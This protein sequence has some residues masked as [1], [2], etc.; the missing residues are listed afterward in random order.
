MNIVTNRFGQ[1]DLQTNFEY[2][3]PRTTPQAGTIQESFSYRKR[4]ITWDD[5]GHNSSFSHWFL[6]STN[7]IEYPS[8]IKSQTTSH[9]RSNSQIKYLERDLYTGNP[10][11]TLEI[12]ANENTKLNEIIPAYCVYPE[13][14]LKAI[15]VNNHNMLTQDAAMYTWLSDIGGAKKG[16][17]AGN[18]QT[19]KKDWSYRSWDLSNSRFTDVYYSGKDVYRKES[20]YVW[21]GELEDNSGSKGV[22][23]IKPEYPSYVVIDESNEYPYWNNL[24]S[25]EGGTSSNPWMRVAKVT[26]YT[27]R[28]EPLESVA[29][30]GIYSASKMSADGTKIIGTISNSNYTS[31]ACTGFEDEY[32]LDGWYSSYGSEIISSNPYGNVRVASNDLRKAHT[33]NYYMK[34]S[35]GNYGPIFT[36]KTFI[37]PPMTGLQTGRTYRASVWV[38]MDSPLTAGISASLDGTNVGNTPFKTVTRYDPSVYKIGDWIL[39]YLDFEIPAN[40][41]SS[42]GTGTNDFRVYL[43]N[44]NGTTDAFFDDFRIAPI[45]STLVSYVYDE[46]TG[47]L[48]Y[49]LDNNNLATKF[50]Y[51]WAGRLITTYHETIN[52]GMKKINS[53]QYHDKAF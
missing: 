42:G 38:H 45:P 17:L 40:Y 6:N 5:A 18:I 52:Y 53:Y 50:E 3:D 20:N 16:L 37:G 10:T 41:V 26:R 22:Y 9:G 25:D 27:T 1:I 48:T 13:M 24:Y 43:T 8:T 47:Q 21:K 46:Q 28:S 2:E 31:F 30:N 23:K 19:W 33:G 39:F 34:V 7:L 4:N 32:T 35:P 29:I 44:Y 14:G 15:D 49:I 11:K 12:D 51:D 36:A